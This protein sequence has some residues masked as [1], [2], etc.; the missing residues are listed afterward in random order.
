[1]RAV[2]DE[3]RVCK[4]HHERSEPH[5]RPQYLIESVSR[6]SS[7][8]STAEEE[9]SERAALLVLARLLVALEEEESKEM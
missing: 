1:M 8:R 9:E 2:A 6:S 4:R 5:T 7:H 3:L